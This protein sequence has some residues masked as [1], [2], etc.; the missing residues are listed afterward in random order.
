MARLTRHLYIE[1][2]DDERFRVPHNNNK[3]RELIIR[4][5]FSQRHGDRGTQMFL[6]NGTLILLNGK[7]SVEGD[8]H[9]AWPLW[10]QLPKNIQEMIERG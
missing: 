10:H 9:T 3:G 8:I 1:L 5:V 6:C 4:S 7:E 2:E